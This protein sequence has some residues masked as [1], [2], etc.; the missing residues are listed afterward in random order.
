MN[1]NFLKRKKDFS[2]NLPAKEEIDNKMF[3]IMKEMQSPRK[4][5]S[6]IR[7]R[8]LFTQKLPLHIRQGDTIIQGMP[9][10][11]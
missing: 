1:E 9:I 3:M 2:G 10:D 5:N 7:R 11:I 8:N 4:F 6:P